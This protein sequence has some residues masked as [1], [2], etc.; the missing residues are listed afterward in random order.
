M[1][2]VRLHIFGIIVSIA[3]AP[4]TPVLASNINIDVFASSAPNVFG[5]PSWS[6]YA[7]N[8]LHSL[9]N[10][11]GSTGN[12]N[13]SPTAYEVLVDYFD[14]GDVMVTSFN[15]WR[16][17]ANPVVPFNNEYG[18]RI[19]FG[20]H[21]FGDGGPSSIRFRLSDLSYYINSSDGL[22]NFAGDF[23]GLDFNGTTRYGIDWG[24]DRVKGGGDDTII[25]GVG[26]GSTLIDELVYV[27]VGNAYW[28][29]N[30]AQMVDTSAYI[31]EQELTIT[32]GYVLT[33]GDT[34][35]ATDNTT[36]MVRSAPPPPSNDVPEPVSLTLLGAGLL[37][38]RRIRRSKM[39]A[40]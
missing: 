5:S 21:A 9:E 10:G 23:V 24:T 7:A 28:P 29:A 33:D 17:V 12:R 22:L 4:V 30:I 38:L 15:S 35:G 40:A 25:T 18:N 37:T 27:G 13:L 14:P 3:I 20:L 31:Y 8:A 6:A 11:L 32:G 36:I 39:S 2:R 26:S 19:H 1:R 34:F 16:G